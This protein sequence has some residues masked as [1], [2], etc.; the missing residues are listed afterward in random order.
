VL[1]KLQAYSSNS[2][3]GQN[4]LWNLRD[5]SG[6]VAT[7]TIVAISGI[8]TPAL[9][10]PVTREIY[11]TGLTPGASYTWKW[12]WKVSGGTGSHISWGADAGA[13]FMEIFDAGTVVT[14]TP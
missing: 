9:Y 4:V 3:N 1:V 10:L 14:L 7:T 12:G 11:V 5:G 8:T 2:L 13:S 6:D